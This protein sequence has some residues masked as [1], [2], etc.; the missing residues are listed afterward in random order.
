MAVFASILLAESAVAEFDWPNDDA[1]CREFEE[2]IKACRDP[3]TGAP[4]VESIE[5]CA[6]ANPQLLNESSAD[7]KDGSLA[8]A[9]GS[10]A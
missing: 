9:P 3:R 6:S 8:R 4:V 5:K 10:D 2:L 7:L 1:V